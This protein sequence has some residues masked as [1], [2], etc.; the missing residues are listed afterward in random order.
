MTSLHKCVRDPVPHLIS[1][2][3][4]N[5]LIYLVESAH[6]CTHTSIP[7]CVYV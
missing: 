3:R 2:V 6:A 5:P 1:G 4:I 7:I